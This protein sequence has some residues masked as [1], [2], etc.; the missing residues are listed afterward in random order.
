MANLGSPYIRSHDATVD[1]VGEGFSDMTISPRPDGGGYPSP[2]HLFHPTGDFRDDEEVITSGAAE[3]PEV[4][5]LDEL[6]GTDF[7]A[8][9]AYLDRNP[10][11]R[12]Q[13]IVSRVGIP[14][15][16]ATAFPYGVLR[17]MPVLN[18]LKTWCGAVGDPV[19]TGAGAFSSVTKFMKKE[20][21]EGSI[22]FFVVRI[23]EKLSKAYKYDQKVFSDRGGGG[24]SDEEDEDE[25]EDSDEDDSPM[26]IW[27][28]SELIEKRDK[29]LKD[30]KDT[31]D[32]W[33]EVNR[34][35]I[36]PDVYFIG[37]AKDLYN[38]PRFYIICRNYEYNLHEYLG[39]QAIAGGGFRHAFTFIEQVKQKIS[40]QLVSLV[41]KMVNIGLSFCDIKPGNIVI[42]AS[43]TA[44][45]P[46]NME[47][48][49]ID[50]DKGGVEILGDTAV[51][52]GHR[53]A[54]IQKPVYSFSWSY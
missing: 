19:G 30:A 22:P 38:I 48:K 49:F 43:V 36:S 39:H 24:G 52:S 16:R 1:T 4:A 25:D 2:P 28:P 12:A 14:S 32:F 6:L 8:F 51:L 23:S 3:E 33:V 54:S 44:P 18:A 5:D 29:L 46:R 21:P 47:V 53:G 42:N 15:R 34:Y 20:A 45:D 27:S 26:D 10:E 11:H 17:V 31:T 50:F 41:T 9:D 40:T 13:P 7:N 37:W 35:N